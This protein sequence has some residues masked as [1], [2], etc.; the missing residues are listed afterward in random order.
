MKKEYID[1][2]LNAMIDYLS[3]YRGDHENS[4]YKLT[5]DALADRV[6]DISGD[7][8][9]MPLYT[10]GISDEDR[11]KYIRLMTAQLIVCQENGF[12]DNTTLA[13]LCNLLLK[14]GQ[15]PTAEMS[16]KLMNI[17][18]QCL[19]AAEISKLS[20]GWSDI[21]SDN[22]L[23]Q[24]VA[25]KI[26]E[27]ELKVTHKDTLHYYQN[28][29]TLAVKGDNA[30]LA[31]LNLK[32]YKQHKKP[33][34]I[35]P[36]PCAI[37]VV[38]SESE[39]L[40]KMAATNVLKT[41]SAFWSTVRQMES[42]RPSV[43]SPTSKIKRYQEG[44]VVCVKVTLANHNTINAETIDPRYEPIKG[45][46]F[47]DRSLSLTGID[48][49]E[50]LAF[51]QEKYYAPKEL[52]MMAE[53]QDHPHYPFII[54]PVIVD[55]Y[56]QL[57]ADSQYAE[58]LAYCYD[59]YTYGHRWLTE[60]GLR[61]KI[62]DEEHDD[63]ILDL[64]A[65]VTV[66]ESKVV[67]NEFVTNGKFSANEFTG[68]EDVEEFK[69]QATRNFLEGFLKWTQRPAANSEEK[70]E[71][72]DPEAIQHCISVL[73]YDALNTEETRLRHQK[74]SMANALSVLTDDK[75]N[76]NFLRF[77]IKYLKSLVE[78]AQGGKFKTD[79]EVK[80]DE[81]FAEVP[82]VV[83]KM[84]IIGMLNNYNFELQKLKKDA[85]LMRQKEVDLESVQ[86][87]VDASQTLSG[88][89]PLREIDAIKHAIAKNLFVDDEYE[90]IVDEESEF[91]EEDET[92]E[93]KTSVV[94]DP[95]KTDKPN[96]KR[97]M[98]NILNAVC[99]FLNTEKGGDLYIGVNDQGVALGV[100]KDMAELYKEKRITELSIDKYRLFIENAIENAFKD[101]SGP[102]YGRDIT[103]LF[104]STHIEASASGEK[105][106]RIQIRPYEYGVVEFRD[107][108]GWA[109]DDAKSYIRKSG[110]TVK[111]NDTQREQLLNRRKK[112][113]NSDKQKIQAIK[114]AI[115]E[116]KCI[117]LHNYESSTG[118]RNRTV[119]AYYFKPSIN[120][121]VAFDLDR[122]ENREFK[123]NRF[124]K[125]EVKDQKWKNEAKHLKNPRTDIFHIM[126]S[127]NQKGVKV[128]LEFDNYVKNLLIEE[129]PDAKRLEDTPKS[130]EKLTQI[131]G[132]D[133]WRMETTIFG[134]GGI[135]R[136]YLGLAKRITIVEGEALKKHIKQYLAEITV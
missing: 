129:F 132:T 23:I 68:E 130:G 128:T 25:A 28:K 24:V 136:F 7:L 29:G 11:N 61:L 115:A 125:A 131:T 38:G 86:K 13:A 42:V 106:L 103:G 85:S 30:S 66:E 57:A 27:T 48:R 45:Q 112:E 105:F 8:A 49:S 92:K 10:E 16:E 116:K 111:M 76:G 121:I 1:E 72:I 36:S 41:D 60:N 96:I 21:K 44:D 78:F 107:G 12:I 75:K 58:M 82:T 69:K 110:R 17:C 53:V 67:N 31:A 117:T 35:L 90:S 84:K 73:Y 133:K 77:E 20:V 134:F 124:E 59:K 22:I 52:L 65:Y 5:I 54:R 39:A 55:Y 9:K 108:H 88:V 100:A 99:G 62:M 135:T 51:I 34:P 74:L 32:D 64:F 118:K 127:E 91:G 126:E 71:E 6:A 79:T 63:D 46:V 50:F 47:V 43:A 97:Q 113:N 119:E 26:A 2:N 3:K 81:A 14:T 101:A 56:E 122:G 4:E 40:S 93:F 18:I 123:I 19:G 95:S 114:T 98:K 80:V 89:L 120:A 15:A 94:F 37:K 104:V 87:L 33:V 83:E 102:E 109:D 70:E